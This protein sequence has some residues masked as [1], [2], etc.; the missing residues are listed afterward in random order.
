MQL[1]PGAAAAISRLQHAGCKVVIV[2]SQS[3]VGKGFVR[4]SDVNSVMDRMCRLLRQEALTEE[5]QGAVVGEG[6]RRA[7]K[8][9]DLCDL[10]D[11][12]QGRRQGNS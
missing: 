2:S 5:E 8:Q 11:L 6:G 3:C 10:C 4:T 1:V 12:A 7:V 9:E